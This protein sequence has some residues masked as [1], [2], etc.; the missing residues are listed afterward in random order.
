MTSRTKGGFPATKWY[1]ENEDEE[2]LD[3][4]FDAS[5][6]ANPSAANCSRNSLETEEDSSSSGED[7]EDSRFGLFRSSKRKFAGNTDFR[8]RAPTN[9]KLEKYKFML[10]N[11][12][13]D[14]DIV[15][16]GVFALMDDSY[17][18]FSFTDYPSEVI[19]PFPNS[20]DCEGMHEII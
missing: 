10:V 2:D 20:C 18:G 13:Q 12:E 5:S 6:A 11:I 4:V 3:Y 8:P 16:P 19:C 9:E 15:D 17:M 14:A 7:V 1:I